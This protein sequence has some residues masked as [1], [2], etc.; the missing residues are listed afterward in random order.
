MLYS[1]SVHISKSEYERLDLVLRDLKEVKRPEVIAR[2]QHAR[3]LG[4]LSENAEY[5][6]ARQDQSSIESRILEIESTL[7]HAKI[8]EKES[9]NGDEVIV[10]SVVT[11]K[12]DDGSIVIYAI[13]TTDENGIPVSTTSPIGMALLGKKK[14]DS[15]IIQLPFG[16]LQL[17]ILDIT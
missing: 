8:I 11:S 7:K 5:D 1:L 12:K 2:L 4:D 17:S 13:G 9:S 6:A 14:G 10:G 15:V 3:S 16:E